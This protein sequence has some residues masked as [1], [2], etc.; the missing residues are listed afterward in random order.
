MV[1]VYSVF[2]AIVFYNIAL[3]AVYCLMRRTKFVINYTA[4]SLSL[5]TLLAIL[6]LFIPADFTSAFVI[7]QPELFP[8]FRVLFRSRSLKDRLL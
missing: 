2:S 3:I 5:L 8:Q 7:S 6:R 1:S 4:A